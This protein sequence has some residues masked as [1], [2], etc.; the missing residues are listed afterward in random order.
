MLRRLRI[1]DVVTDITIHRIRLP[2]FVSNSL[3]PCDVHV[4]ADTR[5]V[6]FIMSSK[7]SLY[8]RLFSD[9]AMSLRQMAFLTW[10]VEGKKCILFL[11]PYIFCFVWLTTTSLKSFS[12]LDHFAVIVFMNVDS[13]WWC[14]N[15]GHESSSKMTPRIEK[16]E[17]GGI[18]VGDKGGVVAVTPQWCTSSSELMN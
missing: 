3:W 2:T 7:N 1:V 10:K 16:A 5:C 6:Y 15:C 11:S 9:I 13:N 12:I 17:A 8:G 4:Y 14:N 18:E